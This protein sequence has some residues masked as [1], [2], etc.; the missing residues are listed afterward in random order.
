MPHF[1]ITTIDGRRVRYSDIWQHRNLVFVSLESRDDPYARTLTAG[2]DDFAAAEATLVISTDPV[3]WLPR[4]GVVVADQWGE[5][6]YVFDAHHPDEARR[7]DR[8]GTT[9]L[10]SA[11][12]L[13]DWLNFVRIECPEC[14]P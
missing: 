14:P 8:R 2:A 6:V 12:E 13:I 11:R 9:P 10:P 3:E 4:P 5:I 7:S 1:E